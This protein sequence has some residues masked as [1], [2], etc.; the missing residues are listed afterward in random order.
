[1]PAGPV[2]TIAPPEL[3][4][5]LVTWTI[6]K[7]PVSWLTA[8]VSTAELVWP[9][10]LV[11]MTVHEAI[12]GLTPEQL[13]RMLVF[14]GSIKGGGTEPLGRRVDEILYGSAG[15]EASEEPSGKSSGWS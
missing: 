8:I 7:A 5:A 6:R 11:P 13:A 15:G 4:V 12:E 10:P 14:A 1:M 2:W 9:E 3:V